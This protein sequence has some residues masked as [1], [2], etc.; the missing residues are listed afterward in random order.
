MKPKRILALMVL[1]CLACSTALAYSVD[2]AEGSVVRVLT[3]LSNPGQER[4]VDEKQGVYC[5]LPQSYS[6]TGS[7]FAVGKSPDS[8]Q[9]FVTNRH[10]IDPQV[11]ITVQV[12][13][14]KTD[15]VLGEGEV[16][17]AYRDAKYYLVY[18]DISSASP[19]N[20]LTTSSRT[21]LAILKLESP[22]SKRTAS[23]LCPFD[24]DTM[25]KVNVY[26]LGFPDAAD[27]FLSSDAQDNLDS[28]QVTRTDGVI[29]AFL[30]HQ[31]TGIGELIQTSAAINHGNSGGPLVDENGYVL[32]VNT[33]TM[34]NSQGIHAAVSI[35][36][37]VALLEQNNVPYMTASSTETSDLTPKPD[38]PTA[39]PA[40]EKDEPA[41]SQ[42][43]KQ[44]EL[45]VNPMVFVLI[46]IGVL[47]AVAAWRF[48]RKPQPNPT[49]TPT[50]VLD[51]TLPDSD[52]APVAVT[53]TLIG[54]NGALAGRKFLIS[55][56]TVIGRDP[57]SCQ[58]VLPADTKGVS[59]VHCTI[60]IRDGQVTV[61]DN[62]SSCGTWIDDR[63]LVP[64]E[65]VV[66]H[67]GH[68]LC[69]GSRKQSFIL[70]S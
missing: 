47:I 23:I 53:R 14:L 35:N 50:P 54:E 27:G 5:A 48:S 56:E 6:A 67:R 62:G 70:R 44:D 63:K 16:E 42:I 46:G 32:G 49:P 1:L 58:I 36:E 22:T 52:T 33:Y 18:E 59:R 12:R 24:V 64:G 66:M 37:V 51:P 2:E 30:T 40:P 69:L 57:Q 29:S 55:G 11:S 19:I 43:T 20:L 65:S 7:G 25:K 3:L 8:V 15:E 10:V 41:D 39:S 13:D 26:A 17:I 68:R 60:L 38:E 34:G 31:R 28:T 9:Y 21:D 4:I 61:T 45:A